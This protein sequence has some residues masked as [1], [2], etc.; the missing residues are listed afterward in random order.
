MGFNNHFSAN[1]QNR[2]GNFGVPAALQGLPPIQED[3]E[4]ENPTTGFGLP[5]WLCLA[6]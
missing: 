6:I 2:R 1:R 5:K 3:L 4:P